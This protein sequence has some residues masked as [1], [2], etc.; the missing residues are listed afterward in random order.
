MRLL[1]D[2]QPI[3]QREPFS[4]GSSAEFRKMMNV[5]KQVHEGYGLK[6]YMLYHH[7]HEPLFTP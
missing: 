2:E 1:R 4:F 6:K 3:K 7:Q 5:C